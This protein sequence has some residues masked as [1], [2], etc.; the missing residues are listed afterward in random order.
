M[1]FGPA[2]S[3]PL[4]TG[5]REGIPGFCS[6]FALAP[7]LLA[8]LLTVLRPIARGER[9][10]PSAEHVEDSIPLGIEGCAVGEGICHYEVAVHEM[11]VDH[12]LSVSI[13][14]L[15]VL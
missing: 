11:Y 14:V 4:C 5:T 10:P 9:S 15:I 7:S 2:E 12:A 1:C 6:A 3:W 13:P 8:S